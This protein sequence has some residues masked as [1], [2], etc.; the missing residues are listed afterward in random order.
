MMERPL[1]PPQVRVLSPEQAMEPWVERTPRE[2]PL[3]RV[4][5]QKHS[6]E[7]LYKRDEGSVRKKQ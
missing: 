1:G 5:P 2:A 4:L 3:E 7:Y 6:V